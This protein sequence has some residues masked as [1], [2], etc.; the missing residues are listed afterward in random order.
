MRSQERG[1]KSQINED[2]RRNVKTQGTCH[3]KLT[4]K[5]RPASCL[6]RGPQL[7]STARNRVFLFV[8]VGCSFLPDGEP[9]LTSKAEKGKKIFCLGL[10]FREVRNLSSWRGQQR[11]HDLHRGCA[12]TVRLRLSKL[13]LCLQP[14]PGEAKEN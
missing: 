7:T 6:Q 10:P 13:P 8:A 11:L 2:R 1:L 12:G 14:G 5:S 4:T 9:G 3:F